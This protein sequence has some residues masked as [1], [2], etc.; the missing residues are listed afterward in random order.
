MVIKKL[1]Y[2]YVF[3]V[4][5]I[6]QKFLVNH[7]NS[8]SS[9]QIMRTLY[10]I[11]NGF[12][13]G[14]ICFFLSG[15]K[16]KISS[17]FNNGFQKL[18]NINL[19]EILDLKKE[20]NKMRVYDQRKINNYNQNDFNKKIEEYAFTFESLSKEDLIRLD[21]CKLDLLSNKLVAE[22]VSNK[23]WLD[24]AKNILNVEPKL[25]DV[26]CWYT[27][28][29]KKEIDLN[30]YNAQIWH[31]DVDKL[32]DIKIFI[33][34][35]DVIN[36][37]CGPFEV[38]TNSHKPSFKF[39]K[40]ENNNNFRISN[41]HLKNSIIYNKHSFLGN[42]GTNFVVDTRCLHR[43]GVVKQNFRQ[44]IEIYFSN[45]I[46]G[47]HEYYNDFSRP[48]LSL[49]W[50]SYNTWNNAIKNKPHVYESLFIGKN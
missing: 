15:L 39:V 9:Y 17:K 21:V 13:T 4:D 43:G 37:D 40:Y 14:L 48:K 27:L 28:P 18:E 22:L 32:R 30:K 16:Y 24:V 2:I 26:T 42:K 19:Q 8:N 36:L 45:S 6:K 34:L 3:F 7:I 10:R 31:R 5:I 41:E 25:I 47:R 1:K 50:E 12:F 44:V 11:S 23:K 49:E 38:L 46:F 29:H 33:Y 20:I 35:S